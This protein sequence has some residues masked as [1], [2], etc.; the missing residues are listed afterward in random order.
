LDWSICMMFS[1]MYYACAETTI[2]AQRPIV[3]WGREWS[4][5]VKI[6]A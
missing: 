2:D 5:H 3:L 4:A 1:A 6:Q